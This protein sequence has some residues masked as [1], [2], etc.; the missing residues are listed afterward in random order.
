MITF[1]QLREKKDS[2][3]IYHKTYSA[4]MA[5]AYAHAK[6]KGFEVDSDDIDSKVAMGPRKPSNGKS[7]RFTL[8]LKGEKRKML[9]VQVTN[10][11]NKRYELNTYIT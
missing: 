3:P 8:K 7:N 2:Y 11:D 10:L 4:A 6:K 1:D 5:A 9:A